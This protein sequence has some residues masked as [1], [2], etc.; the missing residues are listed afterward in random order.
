MGLRPGFRL[1]ADTQDITAAIA[2]R[3]AS[4]TLTDEA[5]ADADTLEI[6]LADDP[7]APIPLPRTGAELELWLGYDGQAQRMG[8]FVADELELE[9]WPLAM[10]IRARAAPFEATA[11]GKSRIQAQ[12]S[13]SWPKD[14]R[15]VDLV[16]KIAKENGLA[17]AVAASLRDIRPPHLDQTEESD[18]SF[19]VRVLRRYDAA[20][21]PGGGR[22]AVVKRGEGLTTS[23]EAL[24][25]VAL[26]A[27]DCGSFRMTLARRDSPGT[28]VAY[29]HSTRAAKRQQVS[30]GSGEPVK[31][32]RH[33]YPNEPAAVA[34]AQAELD[35]RRRGQARVALTMPGNPALCA[36]APLDL[37]EFRP[38][39][40]GRWIVTRVAHALD[41]SGGYSCEVE[42]EQPG[43]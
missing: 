27:A 11:A 12:K 39:V 29:W 19:L 4:L 20:A 21:K 41:K 2:A 31:V 38:G 10:V 42:A 37:S 24:P 36:E 43:E 13:R 26:R 16:A 7:A 33:S 35:R 6:K 32:L 14:T 17:P 34:A 40:D 23:G 25:A 22:L 1:L 8:L 3:F 30:L 18:L 5:G 9:G 28:V 15:L